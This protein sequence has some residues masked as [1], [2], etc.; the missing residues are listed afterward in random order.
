MAA[1]G[2]SDKTVSV[3]EM[4]MK[5]RCV[6]EFL[7]VEKMAPTDVHHHL[8]DVSGNQS[9]DVSTV[10]LRMVPFSSGDSDNGAC[11]VVQMFTSASCRL[12]FITEENTQVM[13]VTMLRNSVLYLRICFI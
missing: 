7:Y 5:Q 9:V 6:A 1:E 4:H 2:Q 10:R 3:M 13:V 12:L 11:P 8:L